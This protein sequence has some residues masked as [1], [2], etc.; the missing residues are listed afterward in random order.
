MLVGWAW[1][2]EIC[3]WDEV[4]KVLAVP[5]RQLG[6]SAGEVLPVAHG[7]PKGLHKLVSRKNQEAVSS[8][9]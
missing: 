6:S 9:L 4:Y 1:W 8:I 3:G 2:G 5:V 7:W